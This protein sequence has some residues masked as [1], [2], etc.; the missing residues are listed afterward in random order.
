MLVHVNLYPYLQLR[1]RTTQCIG[2]RLSG[3]VDSRLGQPHVITDRRFVNTY[4]LSFYRIFDIDGKIPSVCVYNT[5][6]MT[7]DAP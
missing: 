6:Q 7:L 5:W 1:I 2:Y 4:N 3:G